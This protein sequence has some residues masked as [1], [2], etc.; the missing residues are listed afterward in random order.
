MHEY[1]LRPFL[2]LLFKEYGESK[3]LYSIFGDEAEYQTTNKLQERVREDYILVREHLFMNEFL[4]PMK[5]WMDEK[6][7]TLECK[8]MV[9]LEIT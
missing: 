8:H 5:N 3:Y 7:I 6:N 1:D 2:P 9:D 4:M